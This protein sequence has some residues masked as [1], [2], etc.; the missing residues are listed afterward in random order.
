MRIPANYLVLLR[1]R[2]VLLLELGAEQVTVLAG[3]PDETAERA[4]RLA[5]EHVGVRAAAL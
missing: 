4:L 2:P 3:L 5:V 1:G